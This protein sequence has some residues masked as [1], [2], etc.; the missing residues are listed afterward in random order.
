MC[1]GHSLPTQQT[2]LWRT[3]EITKIRNTSGFINFTST[4]QDILFKNEV[5]AQLKTKKSSEYVVLFDN[6]KLLLKGCQVI[7]LSSRLICLTNVQSLAQIGH[8]P[9]L[10]CHFHYFGNNLIQMNAQLKHDNY[11]AN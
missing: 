1:C 8:F 5:P 10:S 3:V 11:W 2:F 9:D 6:I 4:S 7:Q